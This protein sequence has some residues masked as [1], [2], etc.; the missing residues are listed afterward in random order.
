M[1][2][3]FRAECTLAIVPR[4]AATARNRSRRSSHRSVIGAI[5][6]AFERAAAPTDETGS[7]EGWIADRAQA[8]TWHEHGRLLRHEIRAVVRS[9]M[10]EVVEPCAR[11]HR[12]CSEQA[13]GSVNF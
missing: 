5:R 10:I 13:L 2:G 11:A 8:R 4:N 9:G 3:L 12:T 1:L 7:H 6:E